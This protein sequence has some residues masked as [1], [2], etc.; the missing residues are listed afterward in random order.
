VNKICATIT[1]KTSD[2]MIACL[3]D[4]EKDHDFFELRFDTLKNITPEAIK[5]VVQAK[6]TSVIATVRTQVEGGNFAGSADEYFQLARACYASRAEYVDVELSALNKDSALKDII[7]PERTII[8]YHNFEQTPS[9][10]ELQQILVQMNNAS[11]EA[12]HKIACN[13]ETMQDV[14]R[15]TD[16]QKAQPKGKSIIIAMGERGQILRL[17]GLSLGAFTSFAS[18]DNSPAAPGQMYYRDMKKV[19]SLMESK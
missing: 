8:S 5:I 3:H 10:K 11:T 9:D 15:L 6:T 16:L 14:V 13:A 7:E 4:L 2:E 17:L 19:T 18:A 1:A 12:I